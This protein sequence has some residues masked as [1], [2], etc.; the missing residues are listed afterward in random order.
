MNDAHIKPAKEDVVRYRP[1]KAII[2]AYD[3]NDQE[4]FNRIINVCS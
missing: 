1:V 4:N 2:K 3:K